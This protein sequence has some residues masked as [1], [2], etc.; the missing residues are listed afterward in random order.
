MGRGDTLKRRGKT[1]NQDPGWEIIENRYTDGLTLRRPFEQRWLISMAFYA[2]RQ[3]TFFNQSA[4]VL[5]QLRAVKGKLRTV[6]NQLMPRVRRQ[7]SDA[8]RNEPIISVIP[9]TTDDEDIKAAKVGDKVL[10]SWWRSNRMK[11]KN[12]KMNYWKFVTG[13]CF[14]DDQWNP[15][16]GLVEVDEKTGDLVYS[17][18][19]D[20]GVWSPFEVLVPYASLGD[21]ELDNFPWI[22]KHKWRSLEWIEA[23]LPG[24]EKVAP[25]QMPKQQLDSSHIFGV[26]AGTAGSKV[27]GATVKEVYIKPNSTYPKGLHFVGAN[28]TVNIRDEYPFT[29]YNLQH[30]KDVEIPGV[31]WGMA[32]MEYAIPLQK[33]W[34]R[35]MT[36]VDEFNR[37]LG[38]GKGLVPRGAKL[39]ALPDD[40]NGEWITYKPVMGQKP[41]FMRMTSLPR[42]YDLS[43]SLLRQS[44]QDLFSQQE[45][46][47]GTNKSDIRS[48][49]MV[50]LLLEQNA[51]GAIPTHADSE[52]A[53]EELMARV[54]KRIQVGY[55][56]QRVLKITGNEGEYELIEFQGADLRNN[57]D[58]RVKRESSLPE[59]RVARNAIVE[60]RYQAG[61]YGDPTDSEVR[62]HVMNMLDDAI[63]KDIYTDER[64]DEANARIENKTM[65]QGEITNLL[66]NDY[67]NHG[68]HILEHNHWRKSRDYQNLKLQAPEA[69][70]QLEI[71]VTNHVMQHVRFFQE[72]QEAQ[73]RLLEGGKGNGGGR[74]EGGG[75]EGQAQG[76]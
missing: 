43:F 1:K 11:R 36:S 74:K 22:L 30:F 61:F 70:Q 67:D 54:L 16:A 23:N 51:M 5:Q 26:M 45:V 56:E 33:S 32:T 31:F 8:I 50:E 65:E 53:Y 47:K 4:W 37:T 48:G 21:D 3:Y 60:R 71:L 73:L 29:K 68:L 42:T 14:L 64:L 25:E 9:N 76:A 27:P 72:Q 12:R 19:V 6:D 17:G 2:G 59:S 15:K 7:V 38:K 24:G 49:E 13:N 57:T 62:R 69:Y 52:E 75:N 44:L 34:N 46:T 55:K 58:V 28:G 66:V 18:D 35:N 41:E 39:E 20:V 10:K 63:V 40:N